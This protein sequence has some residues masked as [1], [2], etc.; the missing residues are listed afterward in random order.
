MAPRSRRQADGLDF[1]EGELAAL[2]AAGLTRTLRRVTSPPGSVIE[3]DGRRVVSFSSNDYLG[4]ASHQALGAAAAAAA[5]AWGGGAGASRL[6]AGNLELHAKLEAALAAFHG[7]EA[8]LLFNSGYHANVGV[9]SALAG[10]EDL[11]VSDELNHA[12]LIDG[13]RLSRA[14]VAVYRHAD[15]DHAA[16]LLAGAARRRFLVTESVFSMDGDQAP[17]ANLAA[18]CDR[19]GAALVVDEAHAVG[20]MGPGGRGIAADLALTPAVLIGTLGKAFGSF[21]GYVAGSRLL[22][23]WLLNRARSF[24]FTTALPP[25][26]VAASSAAVD[27][28]SGADGEA[29]RAALAL[30]SRQIAAGLASL[31]LG[32][33]SK[34]AIHPVVIGDERAAMAASEALLAGGHYVQ[35]IRPPTVPRGTSRLRI[36]VSS[37]HGAD[38]VEGLLAALARLPGLSTG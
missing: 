25:A 38:Q 4:L 34:S 29:R 13:C 8:A 31:G 22:R 6:I 35:G 23:D 11:I 12:S 36:A 16:S 7:A 28:V 14:R 37:G 21:G 10:P 17:L 3:L 20:A 19:A 15:A 9:V 24:V 2:E 30:R 1:L 18:A 32:G 5:A 26:V 33:R 27:L